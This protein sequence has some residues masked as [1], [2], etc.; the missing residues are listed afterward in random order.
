M[1]EPVFTRDRVAMGAFEMKRKASFSRLTTPL[2]RPTS[3]AYEEPL[4][5]AENT[6]A[7]NVRNNK[8]WE[9]M[10]KYL[11]TDTQTIQ[12]AIVNHVEYTLIK[13]RW[14]MD[15]EN[16]YLATA[17]S[18]RDRLVEMFNDTNQ[19]FFSRDYKR[20]YYLSMEYL[21]GRCMQNVLVNL[22]IEQQYRKAL[23]E[24]GY[25]LETLYDYE[26]EAGLGFGSRGRL[27]ANFLD[28]MATCNYACWGYGI[29]YTY[30]VFEQIIVD[31]W[32]KERPDYWLAAE[33]PWE[34]PRPDVTYAVRFGGEVIENKTEDG[35]V[36][37]R[38]TGGH[39]VQAVAYD[40]IIPGFDTFNCINLRLWKATPSKEFDFECFNEGRYLDAIK[41]RQEAEIITAV[42]YPND[43]SDSGKELKLKQQYFFVCAT[44]Q[45]VLRRFKKKPNRD[46]KELP[47]KMVI[48]LNDT[49]PCIAIP[50]LI[51]ILVDVEALP[52]ELAVSLSRQVFHMT[53]H[54]TKPEAMEK[55][56][57]A[58]IEK[59]LPR[60]I[61][62]MNDLNLDFLNAVRASNINSTAISRMSV[63]EGRTIRMANLAVMGCRK[64][65]GV[66]TY[67]YDFIKN[68]L[69]PDFTE[70][71]KLK[72]QP[73]KFL[74]V[75]NGISPRKWLYCSNK[76]LSDL[77]S[78]WL[79]SDS[80][81]KDLH[82]TAGLMNH[83]D[84]DDFLDE[85]ATVKMKNKERLAR[86]VASLGG[87]KVNAQEMLF[88]IQLAHMALYKRQHLNAF[89]MLHHYLT[90]KR[91]SREEREEAFATQ[92]SPTSP[93]H[94]PMTKRASFIGGKSAPSSAM[95]KTLIKLLTSVARLIN[96]DPDVNE[97]YKVFYI[98]NCTTSLAQIILPGADAGQHPSVPGFE[99]SATTCVAFM[100][101]GALFLGTCDEATTEIINEVGLKRA[102][103]YG[104]GVNEV[105]Q[106]KRK[107]LQ[108]K[109]PLDKRLV[110]VF[111]FIK[112]G[113]LAQGDTV[114]HK[115][116]VDLL[117]QLLKDDP[118]L[119]CYDFASY[120]MAQTELEALYKTNRRRWHQI[121]V[122]TTASMGKFSS[123]RAIREYAVRIW[124]MR[125]TERP[126]PQQH[127]FRRLA[128]GSGSPKSMTRGIL[129]GNPDSPHDEVA[130]RMMRDR[131]PLLRSDTE[132]AL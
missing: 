105:I 106:I 40:N 130:S 68:E 55:W 100:V 132:K 81:I 83:I 46:W 74:I 107:D 44:I 27:A 41:E 126:A 21:L 117:D 15:D 5:E 61:R 95:G 45:D 96:N 67:Q 11:A 9:L 13:N 18:I 16:C 54:T 25:R 8:M 24:L 109:T 28:S 34:C 70:W 31:G 79:G 62:I 101:N 19:F 98:P 30:G 118:H 92:T 121:S 75:A 36:K 129:R 1:P 32:Q 51:R 64:I 78:S 60:H 69:F 84:D 4:P 37:F 66:G 43:S 99:A 124:N 35:K 39:I 88:D 48:Q 17:Y 119:V 93:T 52:W 125:P 2:E 72:G 65:I 108:R 49:H 76:L 6:Q 29:R 53:N 58:L 47:H 38:W 85:W 110:D 56:P 73:D 102:F 42:L 116:F 7:S 86:L 97:Y 82:I 50:E 112:A 131:P 122:A 63:Y 10:S 128:S 104:A 80:W 59:L 120:C 22:D 26:H 115:Q 111:E 114:A 77:I 20:C 23:A 71:F 113:H 57:A 90:I 89:W 94:T 12:R 3:S 123:D 91:M 127:Q 14:N 87:P 103:V 33:N